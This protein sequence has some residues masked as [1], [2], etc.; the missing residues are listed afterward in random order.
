MVV[1]RLSRGGTKKRPFYQI[2]VADKRAPRDGRFIEKLG[3]YNPLA[4]RDTKERITINLERLC[5]WE[6]K[7]AQ[8]SDRVKKLKEI[9]SN[10]KPGKVCEAP[11]A[12]KVKEAES[13]IEKR[14]ENLNK[15]KNK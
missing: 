14:K 11:S 6:S 13:N 9:F 1:I 8:M 10:I 2:R 5:Y 3:Y 7:G 12:E 15:D 4:A